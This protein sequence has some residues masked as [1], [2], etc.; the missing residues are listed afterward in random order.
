M[1][2]PGGSNPVNTDTEGAIESIHINGVSRGSSNPVN[3]DTEG[4]IESVHINGVSGGVQT[5]LTRTL[6]EP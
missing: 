3:T 2:C 1:G 4:A 5:P 6:R